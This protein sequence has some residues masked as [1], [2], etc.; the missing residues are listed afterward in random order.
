MASNFSMIYMFDKYAEVKYYGPDFLMYKG[1]AFVPFSIDV[2]DVIQRLYPNDYPDIVFT[3]GHHSTGLFTALK[4]FEKAKC[5]RVIWLLELHNDIML[6]N[7]Y[8]FLKSGGADLVLKSHDYYNMSEYG[9]R[10]KDLNIPV[11]WY[12]H[13]IDPNLFFDRKLPKIYDVTNIGQ[14]TTQHYPLRYRAHEVLSNQTEIKYMSSPTKYIYGEEYAK[15]INQS[16]IFLTDT[17]SFRFAIPK[18]YEI[19]AS[20]TLLL[21]TAP[22]SAEIIGLKDGLNYVEIKDMAPEASRVNVDSFME[23]IRYYLQH[24]DETAQIA[25]RGH[26]LVHSKHTHDIRA[27]EMIKIF[28]KYL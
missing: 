5:L 26:D 1:E 6:P 12:P 23:P 9:Q 16:K 24:P 14:F 28:E 4:N 20:N 3:W 21:T 8:E 22:R 13:S 18:L 15:I 11:E 17:S 10:L 7:I 2:L 19:M 25:Q 27:Q